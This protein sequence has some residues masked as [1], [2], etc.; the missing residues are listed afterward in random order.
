MRTHETRVHLTAVGV[1]TIM[2]IGVAAPPGQ[3]TE[4]PFGEAEL[5]FELNNTDGDLGIH[6]KIDG[7]DWKNLWI[8]DPGDRIILSVSAQGRMRRQGLTEF[9]FE[10]AEPPFDELAPADFLARFPEGTYDI[11]ATTL[12]G[13]ELESEVTIT[14]VL[15]GPPKFRFPTLASCDDPVTVAAPVTV[16]WHKVM[17][18]HPTIGRPHQPVEVERYEVA[19][20]RIDSNLTAYFELP[21]EVTALA[22][23][24]RFTSRPGVV[25]VEVLVKAADGNRTAEESCFRIP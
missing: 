23:P 3:A 16:A 8:K 2:G 17:Q 10:S 9:D 24:W 19:F 12:D 11:E 5:F 7:D 15:P 6:A 4:T 21:P 25:K 20:E 13:G 14:H 18:S 1:A 22:V